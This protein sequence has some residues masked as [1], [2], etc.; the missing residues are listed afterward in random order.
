MMAR[1]RRL[2]LSRSRFNQ[3]VTRA[4]QL[5]AGNLEMAQRSIPAPPKPAR[6]RRMR[7]FHLL[8]DALNHL[9]PRIAMGMG[10]DPLFVS[11]HEDPRLVALITQ[12][13]KKDVSQAPN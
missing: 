1:E 12:A 7:H 2:R 13:K 6:D 8:I 11:L 9:P 10:S 3:V 5:A 4:P